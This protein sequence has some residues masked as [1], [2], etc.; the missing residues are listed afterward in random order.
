MN[1]FELNAEM[2]SQMR[3]GA[4]RRLR[5]EGFVPAIVYGADFEPICIKVLHN[6]IMRALQER[7]FY[8]RVLTLIIDGKKEWVVLKD[9]QRHPY[10]RQIMHLDFLRI[11][12]NE[13][14]A[15]DISLNFIGEEEALGIIGEARI[16]HHLKEVEIEC[17]PVDLPDSIDVDVSQLKLNQTLHLSD[18]KLPEK[19]EFTADIEIDDENLPVVSIQLPEERVEVEEVAPVET[20]ILTAKT[21]EKQQ[22][23]KKENNKKS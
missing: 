9:V 17:F 22:A 18:I 15:R 13:K 19:V 5:K 4:S 6:T 8:S 10:K 14:L 21:S 3:K 1:I 11:K 23:E 20:E 2:R 7:A 16:M 12:E